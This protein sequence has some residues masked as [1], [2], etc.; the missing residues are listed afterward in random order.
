MD[1]V[2]NHS[3][4]LHLWF[5]KSIAREGKYEDYYVW[6]DPK[7]FNA[8]GHPIPPNNWLSSFGFSAW[9]WNDVRQQFYLH[10]FVPGQPDLNYE[11]N[12]VLNDMLAAMK[13]WVDKGVDGFRM[14]TVPS[15]FEDQRFLDE[16]V[17]PN[18]PPGTIPTD[19]DYLV[20]IYTYNQPD[21]LKALAEYRRILD[22]YNAEDD[23]DR[24]MMV[25]AYVNPL[26]DLFKYYGTKKDPI[27]HFPFNFEFIKRV[28]KNFNGTDIAG[29]VDEWLEKMPEGNTANWL[30]GN[31]DQP[32]IASRFSSEV[33]D[34]FNMLIMLLP[35]SQVTYYGEE[36]GMI[37]QTSAGRIL[38]THLGAMLDLTDITC[39]P[40]TLPELACNG[41]QRRM[42]DSPLPT[43]LGCQ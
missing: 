18:P 23:R 31:H 16:P 20:H 24:C 34:A 40:G 9:E 29:V 38:W 8:T 17:N 35:G 36:I 13:F 6:K 26:E 15:M 25:E 4:D 11:N 27:A 2:P 39:S 10:Q 3:S 22:V 5:N 7:G 42:L 28:T 32:R 14:D 43:K 33:V 30:L 37:M 21:T 41:M 1:F 12:D 19:P